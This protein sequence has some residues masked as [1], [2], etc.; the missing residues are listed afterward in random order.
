MRVTMLG[1]GGSAG[2]PHI[3]CSCPVCISTNPKNKRLRVSVLIEDED[4]SLLVDTGPDLR[5][6]AL[7]HDIRRVDAVFYTH[8]HADH[9][10]GIDDLRGFNFLKDGPL[11]AYADAFTMSELQNRF[12]YAFKPPIPEYGWFRAC[13]TPRIIEPGPVQ[14]GP[15]KTTVFQQRH[16]R[17]FSLGLRIGN[18]AYSTDVNHLSEENFAD[19]QGIDTWIVDCLRHEPAPTHAHLEL[20]LEWIAR[21]KPRRAILTH[22]SHELEYEALRRTLPPGVEPGYDGLIVNL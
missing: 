14:I 2:V 9:S 19:L 1:S 11:G 20:A 21:V 12:D 10:H 13:L 5:Q 18:F 16:G 22:M 8:A 6:Q 4:F 17:I 15:W 3:G 7:T